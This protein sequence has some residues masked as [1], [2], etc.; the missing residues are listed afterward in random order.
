MLG[1]MP[2]QHMRQ[3]KPGLVIL[4]ALIFLLPGNVR[5]EEVIH[6]FQGL[7]LRGNLELADGKSLK[8]G[9]A[10]IVHG[11]MSHNRMEMIATLQEN[12][13]ARGLN[14]LAITLS[15]GL[16]RREGPYPCDI[17]H[18]HRHLDAVDEIRSWISW[19]KIAGAKRVTL[20]G[21][22]RGGN[23]VALY[24][25]LNRINAEGGLVG[26]ITEN[27]EN[28][29]MIPV[30][31]NGPQPGG[32]EKIRYGGKFPKPDPVVKNVVLIAPMT[33][34][35]EKIR[36]SYPRRFKSLLGPV[37]NEARKRKTEFEGMTLMTDTGFLNC[38]KT[39]VTAD[40][41]VDYYAPNPYYFTP[42]LLRYISIPALV[43]S[44]GNDNIVPD[45]PRAIA[46]GPYLKNVEQAVIGGADHFFRDLHGE[47]LG[48]RI[49]DFIKRGH[50]SKS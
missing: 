32:V 35:F 33:W 23:Q 46:A 47:D 29:S 16:D 24:M 18:N 8:N 13:R 11:T 41:F 45:L 7:D 10:L 38:P 12:L 17:E 1:K 49:A 19:L 20:I 50:R 31:G 36:T 5:A 43:V 2:I 37:L 14:S 28:I 27:V 34:T 42:R 30:S 9:V 25:A 6:E 15:L 21:H 40:A 22:S 4:L 3:M 48:D 26:R 44:G 39:R